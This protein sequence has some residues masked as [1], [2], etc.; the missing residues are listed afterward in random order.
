MAVT[1]SW[2]PVENAVKLKFYQCATK[3]I[4]ADIGVN[5]AISM[6][7]LPSADISRIVQIPRNT[8]NYFLIS[9]VD[10]DNLEIFGEIFSF[11]NFPN[12]GPGSET[13]QRGTWEF[14][15]FGE[16]A[17][18]DLFTGAELGA[19]LTSKGLVN[20][21]TAAN[22]TVWNKC[23]VNGKILFIPDKALFA[24][25]AA[26]TKATLLSQR[27]LSMTAG[28]PGAPIFNKN[29]NDFIYR[30]PLA[31]LSN[32]AGGPL[33]PGVNDNVMGSE[34][35]MLVAC[36]LS[37]ANSYSKIAPNPGTGTYN[38]LDIF[39]DCSPA[40]AG[41]YDGGAVMSANWTTQSDSSQ[42]AVYCVYIGNAAPTYGARQWFWNSG[43]SLSTI[44]GQP[45]L[46]LAF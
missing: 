40:A 32:P 27:G 3:F 12:T 11:G 19:Q 46:E 22:L 24:M 4:Y 41:S 21:I 26:G 15:W 7:E 44:L 39:S 16:V 2:K 13:I 25:P 20:E 17:L 9:G 35:G 23:I 43:V 6:T 28:F 36:S 30:L 29:G 14:G 45:I 37:T 31:T 33:N 8:V 10:A 1:I 18:A 34:L 38:V 5:P 42:W